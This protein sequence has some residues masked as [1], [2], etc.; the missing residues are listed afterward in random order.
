MEV[1][2]GGQARGVA[3]ARR[4]SQDVFKELEATGSA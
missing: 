4:C 3:V 2:H 1:I